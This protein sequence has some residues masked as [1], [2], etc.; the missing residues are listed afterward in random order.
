MRLEV[1][2]P[3]VKWENSVSSVQDEHVSTQ[4]HCIVHIEHYLWGGKELCGW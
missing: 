4:F 1:S 2:V 3:S